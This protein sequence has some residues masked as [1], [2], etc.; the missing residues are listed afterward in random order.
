[1]LCVQVQGQHL[2]LQDCG[3]LAAE[4][5]IVHYDRLTAAARE[6]PPTVAETHKF[7]EFFSGNLC[8]PSLHIRVLLREVLRVELQ[9]QHLLF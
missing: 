5:A 1:V 7:G 8:N 2:L 3:K 9:E 4:P 6:I